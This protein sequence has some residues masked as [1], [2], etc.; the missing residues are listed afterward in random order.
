MLEIG[1][2]HTRMD[3]NTAQEMSQQPAG[4]PEPSKFE[5]M[6]IQMCLGCRLVAHIPTRKHYKP[7]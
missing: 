2:E 7:S 3:A 4:K 5:L 1:S 6:V